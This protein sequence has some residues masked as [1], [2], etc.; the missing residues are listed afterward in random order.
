MIA[1]IDDDVT[2]DRYWLSGLR[3]AIAR[4]PDAAAF[5][6]LVLPSELETE[7][8]I[9]FERA[10]GFEKS[11]ETIRYGQTLPGNPF[12]PC[13]GGKLGTGCN[14]AFLRKVALDL[15]GF[16]EALDTG[17]PLPGGGDSDMLYRIIRAGYPLIYE[18][19]FMVFHRHRRGYDQLRR[20]YCRSWGQGLMAFVV[21]TYG[22]D[23][24][25]RPKLRRLLLWWFGYKL[26]GLSE[27]LRGKHVLP[28][29]LLG[30]GTVGWD[31]RAFRS[32]PPI[33][34]TRRADP[35]A[36]FE[37]TG[38]FPMMRDRVF[39]VGLR[40]PHHARHSGYEAFGRYIG[41]ALAPPVNFRWTQGK[42]G[43]PL[44]QAICRMVRHPRYSLGAHLTEWSS[45]RHMIR[46]R[47]CVYHVLYGDSDLWLLRRANRPTGNR[48][49]ASF[50]QPADHLRGLGSIER[51][52]K[53]P[54]AAILVCD[55][56]RVY[57]EEFLPPTGL[58]WSGT[59]WTPDS[60]TLPDGRT[61]SRSALPLVRICGISKRTGRRSVSS[62]RR[63]RRC[64]SLRSARAVT[65]NR[66]SRNWRIRASGFSTGS[67]TRKCCGRF[68][69]RKSPCSLS[70][71]R[72][73]CNA[74]LECSMAS[75]LPIVATDVGGIREYVGEDAGISARG[76]IRGHS[77]TGSLA[78][79]TM[80]AQGKRWQ[81]PADPKR[82]C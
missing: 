73:Q 26:H 46:N 32:L 75:G 50:H 63:I 56:Q 22:S 14:M 64:A 6:G 69:R 15:G 3:R 67:A 52:A 18:P 34:E 51:I 20:Q 57:F 24:T 37:R 77:R 54:D 1:F 58:S 38:K 12:Y 13:V 65:R 44:N 36:I 71:T 5:T 59:G 60:S 31:H 29:G 19:R 61:T 41:T 39:L 48:L 23:V 74:L 45:L 7:S 62:G 78:S 53:H 17:P 72:P 43:W 16:D 2:I 35:E 82:C 21:K 33:R 76:K 11:F 40:Y 68:R 28:P 80:R 70:K 79:W 55:V 27:S 10:G 9:L 47:D 25:Q 66:I 49:V 4:Y 30:G 42:W 8:Q 81:T